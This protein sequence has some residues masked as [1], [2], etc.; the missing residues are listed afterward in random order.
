M[1]HQALALDSRK[2]ANPRADRNPGAEPSLLVHVG[3]A[4]I[5]DRLARGI[6]AEDDELVDLALDLVVDTL[7]RVE[8]IFVVGGLDL[9]R[10]AALLIARVELGNRTR[11]ALGSDDVLP[12]R[13]DVAAQRRNQPETRHDD[14]AHL[15]DSVNVPRKQTASRMGSGSR[16]CRLSAQ[17]DSFGGPDQPLFWSIYSIASR[18]VVIFSAASSGISTPNSSSNAMTS[19]TMSRLSAPRSSMK[20]ASSVTLSG[21]TPRCSTTI[22]L[23]RS[24][25]SLIVHLSLGAYHCH[26]PSRS[27]RQMASAT[28]RSDHRHAAVHMEGL[29][30]DVARLAAGQIDRRR[31]DVLAGAEIARGNA[32]DDRLP[33]RL[34]QRVG[35]RR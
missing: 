26:R 24:E 10:D 4:G 15:L 7:V 30:G 5:L 28:A 31:G 29:A 33:L 25:V 34:V 8:S 6:E 21:S 35:H 14:T 27:H 11:A 19:S 3:E 17:A 22:F 13:L 2:A 16:S 12:A 18:T 32:P 23:T 9:A 20:L 1:E